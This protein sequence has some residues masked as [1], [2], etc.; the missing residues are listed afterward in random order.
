MSGQDLSST[1]F[2]CPGQLVVVLLMHN[3]QNKLDSRDIIAYVKSAS[4]KNTYS[5]MAIL[6]SKDMTVQSFA[7]SAKKNM[8]QKG[9]SPVAHL[10]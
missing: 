6:F 7:F 5:A 2:I 4:G 10:R 3:P 8:R 9:P 1:W